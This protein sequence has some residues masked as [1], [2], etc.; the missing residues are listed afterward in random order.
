MGPLWSTTHLDI[1]Y[2]EPSFDDKRYPDEALS[3]K[4]YVCV[5]VCVC[6][7]ALILA[8]LP[9]SLSLN[10]IFSSLTNVILPFLSPTPIHS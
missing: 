5:Y 6:V 2:L 1:T 7:H 4:F 3:L 10:P 8:V 9:H